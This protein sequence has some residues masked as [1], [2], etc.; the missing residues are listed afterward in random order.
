MNQLEA[1]RTGYD[2]AFLGDGDPDVTVPCPR[3]LG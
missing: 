2:P 3:A 1:L